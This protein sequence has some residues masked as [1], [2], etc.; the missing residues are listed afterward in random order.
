[1]NAFYQVESTPA[2]AFRR[3]TYYPKIAPR[4]ALKSPTWL[5]PPGRVVSSTIGSGY[6][7]PYY[8]MTNH[9]RFQL[10]LYIDL[11]AI[12]LCF[13]CNG[14]LLLASPM[15]LLLAFCHPFYVYI[16]ALVLY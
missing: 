2:L 8:P 9:P 4:W 7:A 3:G 1:M 14:I 12:V 5:R 13:S 6:F 10:Q 15:A 11:A 16:E